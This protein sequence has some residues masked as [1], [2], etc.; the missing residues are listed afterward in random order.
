[1]TIILLS[2]GFIVTIV[3]L[4]WLYYKLTPKNIP[5]NLAGYFTGAI[6]FIIITVGLVY[7]V[8]FAIEIFF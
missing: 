7:G 8:L 4:L 1:M 2:I 3:A 6:W 5:D